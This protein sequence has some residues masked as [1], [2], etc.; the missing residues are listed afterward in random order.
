MRE[1]S[2]AVGIGN[3]AGV[4]HKRLRDSRMR[5]SI[6]W[7][8][9]GLKI[10]LE[11]ARAW[12]RCTGDVG[13]GRGVF[14]STLMPHLGSSRNSGI[15][16]PV[17]DRDSCAGRVWRAISGWNALKTRIARR[18]A[19]KL[20]GVVRRGALNPTRYGQKANCFGVVARWTRCATAKSQLLCGRGVRTLV[21]HSARTPFV[22]VRLSVQSA[23]PRVPTVPG[24]IDHPRAWSS[25]DDGRRPKDEGRWTTADGRRTTDDGRRTTDDGRWTTADGRHTKHL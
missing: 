10:R 13:L 24:A 11:G 20:R 19:R 5:N 4:A 3:L 16:G 21:R 17:R 23:S 22:F 7:I 1:C 12:V 25:S 18:T 2:P 9:R 15:P 8:C 6:D 14:H